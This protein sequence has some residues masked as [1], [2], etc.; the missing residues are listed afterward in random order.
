[1]FDVIKEQYFAHSKTVR[2]VIRRHKGPGEVFFYCSP[3]T[4]GSTWQ[5]LNLELAKRKGWANTKVK[6]FNQCDLH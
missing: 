3:C 1:M 4:S 5:G 2:E 6:L